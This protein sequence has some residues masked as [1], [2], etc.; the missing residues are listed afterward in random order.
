MKR[1]LFFPGHRILA[2]EWERGAFRRTEAFEPDERGR[3]AFRAWLEE[4]PRTPVQLLLDVIE[5]EFH[6]D[7]IPH[8]IGRD[9]SELF[10]RTAQRHFRSTEFRY[11]VAQG[12]E[13]DGRRDDRVLVAGLTN[14]E[15]LKT[16]LSVI[17]DARVPL[18][19]IHSL[20]LLSEAL[21]PALGAAKKP[22][23]LIISQQIPSTLR[24][25]YH[26]HGRLRFSRLAPG[27]YSDAAGFA[28]FVQRELDQT[29]HF[30]ETQRF[31]RQGAPID[32]YILVNNEVVH[33]LRD[34]LGSSE[35]VTCHLVP[36]DRVAK[37]IGL[38]GARVGAFADTIYGHLLLRRRRPE[39]H[40]GL[41]RLRRHFFAQQV[42]VA[43]NTLA[44]VLVLAAL[45]TGVGVYLRA[46]VYDQ[47]IAEAR[48]RAE[49][50]NRRYEQRLQQLA[51]FDYRAQ[52]VKNAVD[53]FSE[54]RRQRAVHPGRALGTLGDV[55]DGQPNILVDDL[56]WRP[57]SDPNLTVDG[58]GDTPLGAGEDNDLLR[59]LDGSGDG[60]TRWEYLLV[61]GTVVGFEGEYRRAVDLFDGFVQA[62]RRHPAIGR[63]D[64]VE[65]PFALESDTAFSGDSG[66]AARDQRARSAGYRVLVRL[67]GDDG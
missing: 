45:A 16:W 52:D 62:L 26:E 56:A 6:T 15:L 43:L 58:S 2:Y 44:A 42:R 3:A 60:Q 31:R 51:A 8:V 28:A 10:K 61:G 66:V 53:L 57:T 17:E 9:R 18:K 49:E 36:L 63:V 23:A 32:V 1:L 11:I 5:E 55:L 20:P 25:S 39:N 21:L 24:Q 13:P 47:S 30:L 14:P 59:A 54:L 34:H 41:A 29:L 7:R 12:R 37:R 19:G 46:Q 27:R 22:R 48:A 4:A 65:A 67:G 38:R 50:F 33:A 64:V 40:Y 35:T